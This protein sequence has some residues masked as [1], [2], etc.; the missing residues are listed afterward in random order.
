MS[1]EDWRNRKKW[2]AYEAAACEMIERTSTENAPWV[3][4]PAVDKNLARITVLKTVGR[5]LEKALD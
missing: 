2:D 5:A 3:P 1:E 4:V